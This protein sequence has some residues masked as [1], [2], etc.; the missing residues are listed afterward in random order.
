MKK[1]FSGNL[2][3]QTCVFCVAPILVREIWLLIKQNKNWKQTPSALEG[4]KAG[5]CQSHCVRLNSL[6]PPHWSVESKQ[7][8]CGPELHRKRP[9]SNMQKNW[10]PRAA[11]G[12]NGHRTHFFWDSRDRG[13]PMSWR[14]DWRTDP[15]KPA[16]SLFMMTNA[17]F[18]EDVLAQPFHQWGPDPQV[19]FTLWLSQSPSTPPARTGSAASTQVRAQMPINISICS[20]N[21]DLSGV[22]GSRSDCATVWGGLKQF[23]LGAYLSEMLSSALPK[24]CSYCKRSVRGSCVL[25]KVGF[26]YRRN[27]GNT[28]NY[29]TPWPVRRPTIKGHWLCLFYH[30]IHFLDYETPSQRKCSHLS[31]NIACEMQGW[32]DSSHWPRVWNVLSSSSIKYQWWTVSFYSVFCDTG[33]HLY[34]T[35]LHESKPIPAHFC[36]WHPTKGLAQIA[37]QLIN[38]QPQSE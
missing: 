25:W 16:L 18:C 26:C 11:R 27:S 34:L 33:L 35:Y 13:G 8:R 12:F 2:F 15:R 24:L 31:G 23:R 17:T 4:T 37:A 28:T 19:A 14:M 22:F 21:D 38:R 29:T 1:S 36:T 9:H 6:D 3:H 30:F 20:G 10:M 5:T 7:G 32:T